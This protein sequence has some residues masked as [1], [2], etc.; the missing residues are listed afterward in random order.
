MKEAFIRNRIFFYASLIAAFLYL[1]SFVIN[2]Q[3]VKPGAHGKAIKYCVIGFDTIP[4]TSEVPADVGGR[5][6][7]NVSSQQDINCFAWWEFISLNWS[8]PE[9]DFFGKPYDTMYPV[10]WE[11]YITKEDLFPPNGAPPVPW[12]SLQAV[13]KNVM[14]GGKRVATNSKILTVTSKVSKEAMSRFDSTVIDSSG[15]QQVFP[16][17]GPNWLGAQNNTNVWYEV[18]LNKDLYKYV[19]ANQFYN[20]NNQLAYVSKG[21]RMSLPYGIPNTD[22]IGAIECKA[23]WMEATDINNPKWKRYKLS[24][25]VVQ[26]LNTGLYRNTILALVGLHIL[27]KTQSQQ[28]WVW[29][30]FEQVDNVPANPGNVCDTC[31]YNFYNPH[32]SNCPPNQPPSYYIKPGGLGPAPIQVTRVNALDQSATSV[33]ST[34]QKFIAQNYPGSVWQYYQLVNVIWSQNFGKTSQDSLRVPLNTTILNQPG[35][36]VANTTLET[37]IQ[38]SACFS[39]H[40]GATIAGSETFA[41]DFSFAMGAASAPAGKKSLHKRSK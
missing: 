11:T 7:N 24:K 27:H 10:Q 31:A 5:Y 25:A 39:C 22:T 34:V 12:N 17:N 1:G 18:R 37:Y 30:T 29:A 15:S 26:D 40:K 4:F 32:C 38:G 35:T 19:V 8:L 2:T 36:N 14:L 9:G 6:I 16:F 23:A 28:S 20:A 33:N 41:S 13:K 21:T 3:T